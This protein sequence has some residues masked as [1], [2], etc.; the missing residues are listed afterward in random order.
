MF[1]ALLLIFLFLTSLSAKEV[2]EIKD[3]IHGIRVQ[4]PA[5]WSVKVFPSYVLITSEDMTR[6]I[7]FR[8]YP[9]KNL[10]KVAKALLQETR[11]MGGGITHFKRVKSGVLVRSDLRGYPYVLDPMLPITWGLQG[12]IPPQDYTSLT[13]IIP[14]RRSSLLVTL[15]YPRG[16]SGAQIEEMIGIAK[17]FRFLRRRIPSKRVFIRDPE[18][19]GVAA[20]LRIPEGW[21]FYGTVIP[22]APREIHFVASGRGEFVRR[23]FIK[24]EGAWGPLGGATM[25]SVNGQAYPSQ[26]PIVIDSVRTAAEFLVS[27]WN[28]EGE[29]WKTVEVKELP[30]SGSLR[31]LE[32]SF[33]N[34]IAAMGAVYQH[35][36]SVSILNGG[37]E[38]YGGGL[39]RIS[40]IVGLSMDS[41]SPGTGTRIFQTNLLIITA[42]A[43]SSEKAEGLLTAVMV[44]FR[45]DP[46]WFLSKMWRNIRDQAYWNRVILGV[47]DEHNQ[48]L[49][50]SSIAWANLLSEK[51]FVKDPRT[52][53]IFQVDLSEGRY[54][55]DPSGEMIL[56]GV[57][58]LSELEEVLKA[59][60]WRKLKESLEGFPE[61]WW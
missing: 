14:L 52:G 60:G 23:D 22:Q 42:Q 61:Q 12:R 7:T 32:E 20:T 2:T 21:D 39:R 58:E 49:T 1:K 3:P 27:L 59:R 43:K 10:R 18:T 53:E 44:G 48:F 8:V 38:A 57:R 47:L 34:Q 24:L 50:R 41:Y 54:W 30:K 16:T 31:A 26:M 19:G 11:F 35:Q 37:L 6:F 46:N 40:M 9:G 36:A 5:G 4:L 13:Y 56:G 25:I 15:L 51:T 28:A 17:T 55:R 33:R 45:P 29:D